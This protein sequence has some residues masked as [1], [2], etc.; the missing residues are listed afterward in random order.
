M[1]KLFY[2]FIT[3]AL[4]LGIFTT[5]KKDVTATKDVA[6]TGIK[7]DENSLTL[8]VGGTKTLIA[9]ILPENA[10]NKTVIWTSS[11]PLVVVVANGFITAIDNG[12]ATITVTTIEGNY[13]ASCNV[14]VGYKLPVLST[15]SATEIMYNRATLGGNIT[16][17]GFPVYFEKGICF[18]LNQNPTIN[19][20]KIIATGTGIG[21]YTSSATDLSEKTTYYARAYATNALGTAYGNQISF[22]TPDLCAYVRFN[23]KYTY[24]PLVQKMGVFSIYDEEFVIYSCGSG[25]VSQYFEIPVGVHIPKWCSEIPYSDDCTWVNCFDYSP[26]YNFQAGRKYTLISKE[27]YYSPEFSI[28]DDGPR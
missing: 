4:L 3:A 19:D 16:D 17:A 20:W 1:K 12:L 11:N 2:L 9:N 8:E 28:T 18:S 15:L 21:N 22:T 5:C 13:S 23:P 7:F 26:T 6:V 24:G 25:E 14:V 10:T 27:G